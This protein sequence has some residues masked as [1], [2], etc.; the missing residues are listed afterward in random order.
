MNI[1]YIYA[2]LRNKDSPTAKAGT[3][4]YI[5]KGSGPR[6]R[7]T[8]RANGKGVHTPK[9][10]TYI[11]ILESSL[12]ELGAFALERR[13]I[14]WWGRKDIGTGILNN[15]T[16]GGEGGSGCKGWSTGLK[17][18]PLSAERRNKISEANKG[19]T[20]GIL[21]GPQ[22]FPSRTKLVYVCPHCSK[23]GS[24][25]VMKKYHFDNCL[26][27]PNPLPRKTVTCPY[28]DKKGQKGVMDMWHFNNCKRRIV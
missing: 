15:K 12:T 6:A 25:N 21:R 28:C 4:Y 26:Q 19:K 5:G 7:K 14:N 18:G 10:R 27:S 13:M 3:P 11:V 22:K 17:L 2:Y 24:G 1:Y 23:T 8:H 9:D 16:D 20:K